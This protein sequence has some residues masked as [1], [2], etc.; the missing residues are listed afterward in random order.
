M[1]TPITYNP[2][3]QIVSQVRSNDSYAWTGH[4]NVDRNY[5]AN[6]L[7]QYASAGGTSITHDARGNLATSG[8]DSYGYDKLN[9]LTSAP[10]AALA[11]DPAGRLQQLT[12]AETTR[13]VYSASA[14]VA[15]KSTSG[16]ILRRYVP[17]PGVD[18]PVVWYEGSSTTDRRWLQ[19]DERGSI[20]ALSNASGTS[21]GINRFDEYGIP[22]AGNLG[23]FQ[24]TGQTW[25]ADT[26]MYNYKARMYSPTLG[27]FMQ[28]DPIGYADGLNWYNY[29]GSDPVNFTDPTGLSCNQYPGGYVVYNDNNGNGVVDDGIDTL[30]EIVSCGGGSGGLSGYYVFRF[31]EVPSGGG[32][33]GN[34]SGGSH[35]GIPPDKPENCLSN[36]DW[37][38]WT[39]LGLDAAGVV[40]SLTGLKAAWTI[41]SSMAGFASGVTS[42]YLNAVTGNGVSL[43]LAGF[44]TS[45]AYAGSFEGTS[46]LATNLP[47]VGVAAAVGVTAYDAIE[48]LDKAGCF[49]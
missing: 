29:V 16:T 28:T 33:G 15:E 6:G 19:A 8:S 43:G 30:I 48:A 17:G 24:Y 18:E 32:R 35:T 41:G 20:V 27:R 49:K 21:I 12:G 37:E 23:R 4:Y 45:L 2:A 13:F 40:A 22:Q 44:S 11:Y 38:T 14:L 42:M 36:I 25:I 7:N 5:T 39:G 9:Q 10:G 1:G 31:T 34:D 46:R 47:V 3:G 26:G